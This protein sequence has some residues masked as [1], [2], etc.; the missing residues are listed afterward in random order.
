MKNQ[1]MAFHIFYASDA[2]PIITD[3]VKP[4]V[5]RKRAEGILAQWFFIRYWL[6]GPHLR[7]RILPTSTEVTDQLRNDFLEEVNKFLDHRPALYET[8]PE[9]TREIYEKF[10]L[11][12]YGIDEWNRRYGVDGKMPF[13]AN[14]SIE[15]FE[16]EPEYKRYGGRVG[17]EIGEWHF[18]RSSDV[19]AELLERSNTQIRPLLLGLSMQLSLIMAYAFLEKDESVGRFFNSYRIFWETTY[20]EPSDSYH[21]NFDKSFLLNQDSLKERI[22]RIKSELHLEVDS[23]PKLERMWLVHCRELRNRIWEALPDLDFGAQYSFSTDTVKRFEEAASILLS[24]YIHMT[25]NR[26]GAAILDEIYISYLVEKNIFSSEGM[27]K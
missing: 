20:A 16:Y 17:M 21:D 3:C 25:N 8:D 4:F 7:V 10:F 6:E 12:E 24:S 26:L 23:L 5:E 1:W 11:A 2:T 15:E 27:N 9:S 19:V 14:N 18:E 13:R 22:R